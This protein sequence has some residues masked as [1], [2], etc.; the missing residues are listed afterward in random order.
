MIS[1]ISVNNISQ[2]P[3]SR[4]QMLIDFLKEHVKY[5]MIELI[6]VIAN[7]MACLISLMIFRKNK[8]K[9]NSRTF[10]RSLKRARKITLVLGYTAVVYLIMAPISFTILTVMT[11]RGLNLTGLLIA[12]LV[13]WLLS[14][15][16][17]FYTGSLLFTEEYR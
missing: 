12:G 7:A 13:K 16:G 17:V 6:A 10:F 2:F 3:T 5:T 1:T 9:Y 14:L 8:Q 11:A 15:E 4:R